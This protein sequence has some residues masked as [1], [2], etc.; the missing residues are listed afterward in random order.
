MPSRS[1]VRSFFSNP[2]SVDIV[3]S[4][5]QIAHS[6]SGKP[7]VVVDLSF[8]HGDSVNDGIPTDSYLGMPFTLRQA[9]VDALVSI[10]RQ[11]G[12]GCHLF[13]KDLSRAYRQLRIDPRDFHLLGYRHNGSLYFDVAPPFGLCS[14]A[15]MCQRTTSAVTYMFQYMGYDCTNYIDD[16]GGAKTPDNST[17]AFNALDD[18]LS[19]LGLQSSPN[20]DCPPST[21]MVLLGIHL[22]TL[23]MTMLVT[24]ERLQELPHRCSSAINLIA[25]PRRDLQSLLGVMS[26][27]T[28]CVRPA[29]IFMSTLLNTLRLYR[30]ALLSSIPRQQV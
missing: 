30:D 28:A 17:A 3:T 12:Q 9:G 16:F 23:A 10:I 15:M 1:N 5:L 27:V 14:S 6:R 29:R 7:R 24:H 25:I 11:K 13:K 8:P 18:L 22:N 2:L 21:A 4:P 19:L 26:F 20:K